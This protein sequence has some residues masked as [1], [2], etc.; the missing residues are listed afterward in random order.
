MMRLHKIITAALFPNTCIGCGA[1]IPE[2]EFL[3]EY[4]FEM[5]ESS[6][7]D[8]LCL[9]CGL[10][11]KNCDCGR[12]IFRF[13]GCIAPF[14]NNGIIRKTMYAFKFRRNQNI[15]K[16]FAQQ[17]ALAVKQ[18]YFGVK[19]DAVCYVPISKIRKL[20]R[21][22]NQSEI[23]AEEI[24]KILKIPV[25]HNTL[26][27]VKRTRRQ[28]KTPIKLR[29]DN[30]KDKFSCDKN[31]QGKTVLLVD[32]IKTSGATL[33]ECARQM[34]Y[35]GVNNVYCVTGLLSMREKKDNKERIN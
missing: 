4:C 27:V 31:V 18:K 9:K 10:P 14:Y 11:K 1:I 6:M 29:F 15:G 17:M 7:K 35:S 30:V 19:F 13:S 3:C 16:F 26:T 2:G 12:F 33:D 22:Y 23:L 28:H 25:L 34:L 20:N 32:D 8:R 21:G 24:A 5:L